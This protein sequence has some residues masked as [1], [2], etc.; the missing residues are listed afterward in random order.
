MEGV[1][2]LHVQK[3]AR[4]YDNYINGLPCLEKRQGCVLHVSDS[5]SIVMS[6]T[7][8]FSTQTDIIGV[9][10][11]FGQVHMHFCLQDL[12]VG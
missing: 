10:Y 3:Q 4:L 5:P 7:A 2:E 6:S 9:P 11:N 1:K 8:H 12:A